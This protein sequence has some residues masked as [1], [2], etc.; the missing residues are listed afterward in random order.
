MAKQITRRDFLNGVTI[1]LAGAAMVSP[2]TALAEAVKSAS[3][4]MLSAGV[5]GSPNGER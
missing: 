4:G 1:S 3:S 5:S 2:Q